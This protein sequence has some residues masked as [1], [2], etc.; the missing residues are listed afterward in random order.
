MHLTINYS[1]TGSETQSAVGSFDWHDQTYTQSGNYQYTLTNAAG[2]DSV[3]TLTLTV[4]PQP[5]NTDLY[6]TACDKFVWE[7]KTYTT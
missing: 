3:V 7:G 6:E 1:N 5:V 4:I 2:C